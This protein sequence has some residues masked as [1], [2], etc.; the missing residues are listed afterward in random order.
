MTNN[1][2]KSKDNDLK[3]Y[4]KRIPY[5]R[6]SGLSTKELEEFIKRETRDLPAMDMEEEFFKGRSEQLIKYYQEK[7]RKNP[8]KIKIWEKLCTAYFLKQQHDKLIESALQV[9]KVDDKNIKILG[10]LAIAYKKKG[11]KER[12]KEIMDKYNPPL[13]FQIDIISDIRKMEKRKFRRS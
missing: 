7:L 13:I 4:Q 5:A 9:L 10:M 2:P 1:K 8:K 3:K 12:Q 11:E 6:I